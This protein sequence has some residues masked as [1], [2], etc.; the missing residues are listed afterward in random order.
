M[1]VDVPLRLEGTASM[2]AEN[3]SRRV[4]ILLVEDNEDDVLLTLRA[5]KKNTVEMEEVVVVRDGAEALDYLFTRG[6]YEQRNQ[7]IMPKLI[8]LDI[9]L[10]KLSG[11]ELLRTIRSDPRTRLIPVVMLTSSVAEQDLLSSYGSGANGYIQKP[12]NTRQFEEVVQQVVNY[13]LGINRAP[14][15][16]SESLQSG[17]LRRHV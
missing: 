15:N 1:E 16:S 9:K 4:S 5:F 14:G 6:A 13:W 3:H 2:L 12:V 7:A 10:P 11:L 17:F 8:L